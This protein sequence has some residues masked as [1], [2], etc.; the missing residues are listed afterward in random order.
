[1]KEIVILG[2]PNGAGKTT[3]ARILLPEF[4]ELHPFL[5]ADEIARDISPLDV[6][7]AAFAAG[8]QLIERMRVL[9]RGGRSFAFETTCSGKS[10]LR[11]LEQCKLDGWRITLIYLWLPAPEDAIARVARRVSQGGHQIPLDVIVRR[12]Y[13]GISNMRNLYLPLADEAEIY[14]NTD[15]KRTLIAEKREGLALIVH[16]SERWARIEEAGL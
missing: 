9:V 14:D 15:W 11:L 6:D 12:Y 3:A 13:S 16:D 2:G 5:N 10:Y 4:L 7:A 1:M 8:R